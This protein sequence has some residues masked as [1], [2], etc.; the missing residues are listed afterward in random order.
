M[1][2]PILYWAAV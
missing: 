1:P 2:K